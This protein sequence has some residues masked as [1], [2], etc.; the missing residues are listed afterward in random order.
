[1]NE[2]TQLRSRLSLAAICA[3]LLAGAPAHATGQIGGVISTSF[4]EAFGACNKSAIVPLD[5]AQDTF[6]LSLTAPCA[7]GSA[8]GTLKGAA[9]SGS[10]GLMVYATGTGA[11]ASMVSLMDLWLLTPPAGTLP[12]DYLIPVHLHVDGTVSAG[13]TSQRPSFLEYSLNLSN[14]YGG[15]GPATAF[16]ANGSVAGVGAYAKTFDS[17]LSVHYFGPGAG[18]Q[19]TVLTTVQMTVF[20]LEHGTVDFYNTAFAALDLPAGWTAVT[21]SGLPVVSAVPEPG[22]ALLALCGAV[23][24]AARR[25]RLWTA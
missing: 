25:R 22:T 20:Q 7:A 14:L 10:A 12:G 9:A 11:V 1:M 15:S 18:L 17:A 5:T 13:A 16:S 4:A 6:S 19:T 21:S 2:T 3:G 24:F 8:G 23:A